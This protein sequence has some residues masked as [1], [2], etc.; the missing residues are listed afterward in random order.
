MSQ[1]AP[2]FASN[3]ESAPLVRMEAL[4][5]WQLRILR[6]NKLTKPKEN[7]TFILMQVLSSKTEE[8][9]ETKTRRNSFIA[10]YFCEF[11]LL[12]Q[13]FSLEIISG[14]SRHFLNPTLLSFEER[15]VFNGAKIYDCN[16][17]F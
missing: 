14:N 17:I 3:T 2:V 15:K 4:L 16:I 8:I 11:P 9:P 7:A 6:V 1:S 5:H 12:L 10:T 13:L